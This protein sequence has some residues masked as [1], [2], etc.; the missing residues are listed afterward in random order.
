MDTFFIGS[1]NLTKLLN[2][3]KKNGKLTKAT[4]EKKIHL[5]ETTIKELKKVVITTKDKN[6]RLTLQHRYLKLKAIAR[7]CCKILH[8]TPPDLEKTLASED[9]KEGESEEQD[10]DEEEDTEKDDE[11]EKEEDSEEEEFSEAFSDFESE[12]EGNEQM[13][14]ILDLTLAMRLIDKYDGEPSK[15]SLFIETVELLVEYSKDVPPAAI[16]KFLKTRLVGAA[17]GA[18]E[19]A[20][21]IQQ[22]FEALKGKF[23]VK[24][25]PRAV[26]K[27]MLSKKQQS[28]NISDFGAEMEKL[29][30]KL[31]A[32]HVSMGTFPNEAAALNIVE[33]VAVQAFIEGLKDPSTKF[34]LKARNPT[35]LNKAI[36]DA[37]EC[38]STPTA[39]NS[40]ESMLTLWC[41]TGRTYHRGNG[42][43]NSRGRG[44]PRGRGSYRGNNGYRGR[45]NHYN[46]NNHRNDNNNYN[47]HRNDNTNYNNNRRGRGMAHVAEQHQ[48]QQQPQQQPIQ[49]QQQE[50]REEA[51]LGELFRE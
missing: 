17:H 26:E 6:V 35:S 14:A 27:E 29:S 51:N 18:I 28:K 8:A 41:T 40:L 34:F 48:R 4:K 1:D 10:N 39:D 33:P 15:L 45:G 25:T 20:Q 44:N 19:N 21:T 13:A 36:S 31:A 5:I 32:A 42:H 22:A 38:Q 16:I 7:E 2:N 50:R 9:V 30:A 47:N 46:N 49:Q 11:E 24:V 3:L 37:L 12:E 23:A 43:N